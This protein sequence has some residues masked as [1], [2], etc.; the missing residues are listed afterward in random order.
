MNS[1]GFIYLGIFILS[2]CAFSI[3][4]GHAPQ[5]VTAD[6][7]IVVCVA[8]AV[9]CT[10]LLDA[11]CDR[12]QGTLHSCLPGGIILWTWQLDSIRVFKWRYFWHVSFSSAFRTVALVSIVGTLM[13]RGRYLKAE[14]SG[15]TILLFTPLNPRQLTD[16]LRGKV[17]NTAVQNNPGVIAGHNRGTDLNYKV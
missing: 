1:R 8:Q 14:T 2:I 17:K 12:K 15:G 5:T 3:T 9:Y 4:E 16:H 10:L 13:C 6:I 7:S 11:R